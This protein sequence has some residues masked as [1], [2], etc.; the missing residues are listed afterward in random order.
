MAQFPAINPTVVQQVFFYHKQNLS[1]TLGALHELYRPVVLRVVPNSKTQASGPAPSAAATQE[2]LRRELSQTRSLRNI[3]LRQATA[4]YMSGRG[5][6]A[7][8]LSHAGR[9]YDDRI[10]A[11]IQTAAK[12]YLRAPNQNQIDLHGLQVHEALQ[13]VKHFVTGCEERLR[14]E[15]GLAQT[16][17][18]ITG[19]GHHSPGGKAKIKPAVKK[20]LLDSGYSI[21][22]QSGVVVVFLSLQ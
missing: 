16:L 22:E 15:G 20:Y 19:E 18:I 5:S 10:S 8:S 1:R 2:A 17:Y 12:Q 7:K 13:L 6:E 4:A 21:K 11:A 3:Y 9:Q 14:K